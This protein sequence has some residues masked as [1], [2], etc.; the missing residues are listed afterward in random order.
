MSR[1]SK[2]NKPTANAMR[3]QAEENRKMLENIKPLKLPSN[4]INKIK[5]KIKNIFKKK[6]K[7]NQKEYRMKDPFK[8]EIASLTPPRKGPNPQGMQE[9]DLAKIGK[10]FKFRGSGDISYEK[11]IKPQTKVKATYNIKKKKFKNVKLRTSLGE[12]ELNL[13][14]DKL[15]T[16]ANYSKDL[17]GGKFN[18]GAYKNPRDKG[19]NVKLVIPFKVGALSN[20]G[21]PHRENGV[22]G[23]DI[24]GVKPIQVKGKK[25]IGVK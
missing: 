21:C 20:L 6:N 12:G 3:I 1:V 10:G 15:S 2:S 25:F 4:N 5:D 19:V 11:K 8:N 13:T 24:K 9:G 23:S 18:V 17:L 14:K 22:Q 7:E 16:T